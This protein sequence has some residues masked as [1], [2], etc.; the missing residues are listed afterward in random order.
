M[1][2][3]TIRIKDEEYPLMATMGAMLRFREETQRDI[4]EM[5]AT[6]IS[7]V[8]TYIYCC[9]AS[10]CEREGK[11]FD[12]TLM[13]FADNISPDEILRWNTALA[14]ETEETETPKGRKKK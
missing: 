3:I 11:A 5:D 6:S 4:S 7:D 9:V 12:Y 2:R 13:Q 1:K 8:C 14:E 10:A